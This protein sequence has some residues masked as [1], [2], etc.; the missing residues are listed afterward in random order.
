MTRKSAA[1]ITAFSSSLSTPIFT[2]SSK[3]VTATAS[4]SPIITAAE[5]FTS[6]V[7]K[8]A[9]RVKSRITAVANGKRNSKRGRSIR[10]TSE[11]TMRNERVSQ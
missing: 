9:S 7:R 5:P 2:G 3:Q 8:E 4:A 6:R 11:V 10:S 1:N